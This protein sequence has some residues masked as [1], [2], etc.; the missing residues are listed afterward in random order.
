MEHRQ[1]G[2]EAAALRSHI[3]T[4][5]GNLE[6]AM[7]LHP[8]APRP[9]IDLSTGINPVPYPVGDLPLETW[10]RLPSGAALNDLSAAAAVAY[11]AADPAMVAAAPGTQAL[12]QWLPRL[13]L[14]RRVAVLGPTYGEHAAA[15]QSAGA[16]VTRV[17]TVEDL[18]DADVAVVVN[19]NNP[20]GRVLAPD[21]L[22]A[23]ADRLARRGGRLV[24]DEAFADGLAGVS[25]V[26]RLGEAEGRGIV[27]LRSFG[28][29]YGL[30][31]VRLGFAVTDAPLAGRI[32]AAL[33]PWAVPGPALAIGRAALRDRDW[34]AGTM[35]RLVADAARLD[36]LLAAAGLTPLG[37]TP[38]FR[39]AEAAE[40]A[41]VWFDRLARAG[42]LTRPFDYAPTWLRFGLPGDV[43]AWDRLQAALAG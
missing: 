33:G 16:A 14:G 18:A 1:E 43:A 22:L 10:T 35:E 37:G 39:L 26:P 40:G 38:L 19:P 29:I 24:V 5:G 42:I 9:W 21:Q 34:L 31:G 23:I 32:R 25:V 17:G 12:I 36:R 28:K 8:E 15:W 3:R 41:D 4:H 13:V 20:D 2:S 6:S 30:A 11:G 27:V 7:A